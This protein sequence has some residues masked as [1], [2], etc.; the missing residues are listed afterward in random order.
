MTDGLL[1]FIV[2]VDDP[3]ALAAREG[4]LGALADA[5]R[6]LIDVSVRTEV[7]DAELDRVAAGI[8]ELADRLEAE[9]SATPLGLV[10]SSDG[11]LRDHGN[12]AVGLRN[13]MAPP[14]RIARGED[15]SAQ[16]TITLGA[17]YEGPPGHVHGGV[18]A[19]VLDQVLGTVPPLVGKPGMTAY[20]NVTYRRP[21]PLGAALTVSADPVEVGEWKVLV[22]GDIRTADGEITAEAEG[23]FVVPR[24]ARHRGAAPQSDA[25]DFDSEHFGGRAGH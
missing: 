23:L 20:L 9:A 13:P 3:V 19:L 15:G 2:P 16:C 24:F 5:V 25:G 14:L 8:G 10:V 18:V 7:D 11:R 1:P 21:T 12:P 6:R 22:R 17:P 4:S